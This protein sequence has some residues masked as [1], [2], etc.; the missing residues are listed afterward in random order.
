M[1]NKREN[2]FFRVKVEMVM[3]IYNVSRSKA[4]AMI[5]GNAEKSRSVDEPAKPPRRSIK[6]RSR[7]DDALDEDIMAAEEFFAFE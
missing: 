1:K 5:K 4:L 6:S 7:L 3:R 2:L